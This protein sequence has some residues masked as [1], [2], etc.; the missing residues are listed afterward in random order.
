MT[1][2]ASRLAAKQKRLMDWKKFTAQEVTDAEL[3]RRIEQHLRQFADAL[4]AC[5]EHAKIPSDVIPPELGARVE[6]LERVL[7]ELNESARLR[8]N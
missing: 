2:D 5:E 4:A 3:K 7:E 6:D 8:G 1:L